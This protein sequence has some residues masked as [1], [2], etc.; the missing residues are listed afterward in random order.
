MAVKIQTAWV[1]KGRWK[2]GKQEKKK[3]DTG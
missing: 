2:R 1:R 3:E